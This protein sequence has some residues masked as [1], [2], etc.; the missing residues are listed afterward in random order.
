MLGPKKLRPG[1]I[2]QPRQ[3]LGR[4]CDKPKRAVQEVVD[5]GTSI[6]LQSADML[7]VLS[8]AGNKPISSRS[9]TKL[10]VWHIILEK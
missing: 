8:K 10:S 3:A 4:P 9:G 6:G 2:A 7:S 1:A 5:I